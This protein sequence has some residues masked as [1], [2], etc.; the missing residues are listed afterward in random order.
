[1]AENITRGPSASMGS[2]EI[3]AGT[4][5]SVEPMDGPS[6]S[7]QDSSFPD[8]RTIPFA[9][10]GLLP[11]RVPVFSSGVN[12][13]LMDNIPQ[14]GATNVIATAQIATSATAL[15]LVTAGVGGSVA[16]AATIALGVPILPVGTTVATTAAFAL[17]FGFTT[18]TTVANSSTVTVVDNTLFKLNQWII[19]G[20]VGNAAAT[21]SLITQVQSITTGNTTTITV[22]PSPLTALAN[23]P[24]GQAQLYGWGL[25]PLAA[26]FGPAAV[27]ASVHAFG[28]AIEAG[29]ARVYN[30]RE[31]LSRNIGITLLT[32]QTFSCVVNGWDVWGTPMSEMITLTTQTSAAGKKAFKYIS[33][34]LPGINNTS[35]AIGLG[36]TFG[37]P[38]RVDEWEQTEICWNGS[39]MTNNNGFTAAA[40]ATPSVSTS[41]DVRGSVQV[42][43]AYITGVIGTAVSAVASNGTG[44]LSVLLNMGTWNQIYGTPLTT[45][46][47]FG[48]AQTTS[49]T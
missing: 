25:L 44:R 49:T 24:I 39:A 16:T 18:G 17:D 46:P 47:Q 26:S 29:L 23:A 3:N 32:A 5:A 40:L 42:S 41:G 36:D 34:I 27:S 13:F 37:F 31:M 2:L 19:I 20:N 43:T 38:I 48:V 15:T 1:M 22:K 14:K 45:A 6:I 30:P 11:G 4:S 35:V 9:K 10:D 7:Y 8:I 21:A 28:G 12:A 33:N